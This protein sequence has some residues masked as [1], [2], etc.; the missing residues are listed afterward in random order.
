MHHALQKPRGLAV[1]ATGSG[2]GADDIFY[3]LSVM[4]LERAAMVEQ[5][6]EAKLQRPDILAFMGSIKVAKDDRFDAMG[7]AFRYATRVV[8]TSAR[9]YR[10]VQEALY[11][12]GSPEVPLTARQLAGKFEQLVAEAS[13][14]L[15]T[16]VQTL[17]T[18]PAMEPLIAVLRR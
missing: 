18:L 9:G 17:E 15:Q 12:P 10:P 7:N 4:A 14:R 2:I 5:F 8:V 1:C 3:A 13:S 11:R 6:D 16:T